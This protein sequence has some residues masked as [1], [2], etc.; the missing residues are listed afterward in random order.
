[1]KNTEVEQP[2]RRVAAQARLQPRDDDRAEHGPDEMPG[3]ADVRHDQH[4]AGAL[5]AHRVGR[6]DLVVDRVQ[7]AG[8]SREQARDRECDEAHA[9]RAVADEFGALGIVA[10]RIAHAADGC[11]RERVHQHRRGE[12]PRDDA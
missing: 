9:L 11:T 3:A 1:M 10:H 8:K 6:D 7:P 2:R 5:R 4:R 12:R